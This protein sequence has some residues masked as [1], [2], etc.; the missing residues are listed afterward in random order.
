MAG[1]SP[2]VPGTGGSGLWANPHALALAAMVFWGFAY[3]P[4]A[5]LTETWPPLLAAGARLGLAGILLLAVLAASGRGVRPG[6]RPL[7]IAF[8]GLMQTT[9]F[10][11]ATFIG[12]AEEGAGIAAVLSNTDPLFVALLGALFLREQLVPAQWIGLLAGI[13][14]VGVIVW[15]GALWPPEVSLISLLVV[16]GAVAWSIGTITA[17][18]SVRSSGSPLAI[19]GWQM[20][21]GAVLLVIWSA[22]YEQDG[23]EIGG[24]QIALV[25]GL[26]ALGS[27]A[28]LGLFYL[29]L[30]SGR[31]GE[32]SAWFF[33]IPVIGV[34]TAWPLLGEEPG[35][36][37][38]AGLIA[39]SAGLLLVLAPRAVLGAGRRPFGG[40]PRPTAKG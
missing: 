9:L 5:W 32:V 38:V 13:I 2:G 36:R 16:G 4:S 14:G 26:A 27:A 10:Y 21:F 31:V 11:G 35:L 20:L 23:P 33:L 30:R 8:L 17:A 3:V 1:S 39:V 6:M 24:G 18:R 12:I 19:A 37:L 22:A 34:L 29:S 15:E 28:P 40:D 25:I 7:E